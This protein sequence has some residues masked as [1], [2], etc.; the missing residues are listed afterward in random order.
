MHT[1]SADRVRRDGGV[2]GRNV[3]SV[4]GRGTERE[5]RRAYDSL[6]PE[7]NPRGVG[8][9][10]CRRLRW[11]PKRRRKTNRDLSV[12]NECRSRIARRSC[13][14]ESTSTARHLTPTKGKPTCERERC[15][16]T[17]LDH[18]KKNISQ[19]E[20]PISF[21]CPRCG[22]LESTVAGVQRCSLAKIDV[23]RGGAHGRAAKGPQ[24]PCVPY[25]RNWVK[26]APRFHSGKRPASGQLEVRRWR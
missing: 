9:F 15:L 14:E 1:M 22:G 19:A 3:T 11:V 10:E 23:G 13:S 17:E 16:P 8:V 26:H 21:G 4:L 20:A 6:G 2:L 12:G 25:R 7:A 24:S 18:A 5:L